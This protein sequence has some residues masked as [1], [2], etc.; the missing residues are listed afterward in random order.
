[1]PNRLFIF[2]CFA[3]DSQRILAAVGQFALVGIE[4]CLKVIAL[5]LGI[6]SFAYADGR[7]TLLYDPQFA[8]WHVQSLAH[9][10]GR[11]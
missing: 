3:H 8:F 6:A 7:R 2:G 4:L 1:M 9:L 5:E 11:E 10:A